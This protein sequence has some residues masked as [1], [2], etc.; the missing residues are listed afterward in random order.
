MLA[1]ENGPPRR[2]G[3]KWE[4]WEGGTS[5]TRWEKISAKR[6]GGREKEGKGIPVP[7]ELQRGRRT[8]EIRAVLQRDF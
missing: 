1:E 6:A 3:G 5:R 8:G 7:E 4:S 2:K